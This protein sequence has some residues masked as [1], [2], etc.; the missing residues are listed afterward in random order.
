MYSDDSDGGMQA[1]DFTSERGGA[2][3]QD[4]FKLRPAARGN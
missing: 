1:I 4:A 2:F 3:I